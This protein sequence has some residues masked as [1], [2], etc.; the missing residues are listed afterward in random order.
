M[1]ACRHFYPKHVFMRHSRFQSSNL[2]G[3]W[4]CLGTC[5]SSSGSNFK[6]VNVM[7]KWLNIQNIEDYQL[8]CDAMIQKASSVLTLT[9]WLLWV[10][11]WACATR[12]N[13]RS[14]ESFIAGD[15]YELSRHV[16]RL[17]LFHCTVFSQ[18][19]S[20]TCLFGNSKSWAQTLWKLTFWDHQQRWGKKQKDWIEVHLKRFVSFKI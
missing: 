10:P 19:R 9:H 1:Y 13:S 5:S 7:I 4:I 12:E 8:L 18:I 20:G 15:R 17:L 2:E 14:D 11:F 6:G 16:I 3:S